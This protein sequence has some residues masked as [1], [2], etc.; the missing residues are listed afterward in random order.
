MVETER[1]WCRIFHFALLSFRM[2]EGMEYRPYLM[3]AM[4]DRQSNKIRFYS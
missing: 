3:I 4:D 1:K 2:K